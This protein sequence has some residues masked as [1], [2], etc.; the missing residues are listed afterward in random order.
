M[1]CKRPDTVCINK[2]SVVVSYQFG[3]FLFKIS[4]LSLKTPFFWNI[5]HFIGFFVFP[6][7]DHLGKSYALLT[8]VWVKSM[9][10]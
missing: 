10:S 5:F 4:I 8:K 7:A 6:Y 3:F 1:M 2:F 9:D